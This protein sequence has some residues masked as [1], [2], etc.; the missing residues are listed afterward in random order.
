MLGRGWQI[1]IGFVAATACG[2]QGTDLKNATNSEAGADGQVA[3]GDMTP[4]TDPFAGAPAYV[5]PQ[6]GDTAHNAG[7]ACG[8]K[9]CHGGGE[10]PT[11][12]IGGTIY[13]DYAGSQP[14][15]G[16][17]IRVVDTNG[18]AASTYSDSVG[19]FYIKAG[20]TNVAFPANVGA[21]NGSIQRPMITQLTGA[22]GSCNQAGCHEHPANPQAY[23]PIHIP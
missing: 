10:G 23:D 12:L 8:Q 7:Q 4:F 6:R 2:G 17:E 20:S 3:N 15:V 18:N 11:F 19:N 22:M 14:A 1:A 5:K 9:G 21:R 16:V 13:A